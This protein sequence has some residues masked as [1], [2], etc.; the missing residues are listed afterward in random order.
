MDESNNK[1]PDKNSPPPEGWP[2]A[3]VG[4]RITNKEI[5]TLINSTPIYRNFTPN[6]PSNLQLKNRARSLRK[7]GNFSEVIFWK[8]V[9]KGKFYNI[10]FDRQRVFGNYIVD[11]YIKGLSLVIEI[12]GTS[13]NNKEDYDFER[14]KYIESLGLKIYRISSTRVHH[15]LDNVLEELKEFIVENYGG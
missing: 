7:A 11:F 4:S 12:D 14:Q 8:Q 6:L 1:L 9:H 13:H 15:D 10:D 5:L 3:G 2:Q